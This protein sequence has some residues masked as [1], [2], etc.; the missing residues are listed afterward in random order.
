MATIEDPLRQQR[1]DDK[2][3]A[4]TYLAQAEMLL[5]RGRELREK[6]AARFAEV[7]PAEETDGAG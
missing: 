6:L 4:I 1:H 3:A 2:N 5:A 7:E